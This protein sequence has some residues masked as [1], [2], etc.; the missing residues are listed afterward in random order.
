MEGSKD[1]IMTYDVSQK[2][3]ETENNPKDAEKMIHD[4]LVANL[5]MEKQHMPALGALGKIVGADVVGNAI[6]YKVVVKDTTM[7]EKFRDQSQVDRFQAILC[8]LMHDTPIFSLGGEVSWNFYS[9]PTTKLREIIL[10]GTT[11]RVAP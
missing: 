9:D 6:V 7:I 3:Y 5:N 10:N 8:K 11:C 1:V 4:Y 2:S